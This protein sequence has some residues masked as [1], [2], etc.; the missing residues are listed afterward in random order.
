M[1]F[2]KPEARYLVQSARKILRWA[3]RYEKTVRVKLSLREFESAQGFAKLVDNR[4][5]DAAERMVL[6]RQLEAM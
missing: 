2:T 4:R 3:R 5:R 6:A 1:K